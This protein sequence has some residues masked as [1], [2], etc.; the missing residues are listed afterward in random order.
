MTSDKGIFIRNIYYML[1]YAFQAL[2]PLPEKEITS[3]DFDGVE[4]LL[5]AI[6]VRGVASLLRQGLHREYAECQDT[7]PCQRGRIDIPSTI[8]CKRQRKMLLSC[9]FD[10]FT[11]DNPC[12]RILKAT[13]LLLIGHDN[14]KPE[15]K[16]ELKKLLPFLG[17]VMTVNLGQ[18]NWKAVTF[19]IRERAYTMLLILCQF[20]SQGLLL[21]TEKGKKRMDSFSEESM[22]HLFEKFVLE[23]F[24]KEWHP[25]IHASSSGVEWNLTSEPDP[26]S[27]SLLPAMQTDILLSDGTKTLIIDT[28]YYGKS[29]TLLY[30]KSKLHSAN[31]YQIFSYVKNYY[32]E[33]AGAVAGLL[34]YA[35][36]GSGSIDCSYEIGGNHIGVKTLNLNMEFKGIRQ[37]LDDIVGDYFHKPSSA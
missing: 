25:R 3:E 22:H 2:K 29:L 30:G 21:T 26:V 28:K 15:R 34:L 23:Y 37:Q 20:I 18:L 10:E 13:M 5:A 9:V 7:L 4:D 33:T 14:V 12:N 27:R 35:R 31:L 1:A 24:R 8:T 32:A 19:P 11:E 16:A 36:A 17:N 6:L